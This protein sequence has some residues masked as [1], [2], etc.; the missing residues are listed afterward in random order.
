MLS[1][2]AL[3]DAGTVT[4]DNISAAFSG[5]WDARN[6]VDMAVT[7][8]SK[9][10][11]IPEAD[12]KKAAEAILPVVETKAAPSVCPECGAEMAGATMCPKCGWKYDAA[13]EAKAKEEKAAKDA[14]AELEKRSNVFPLDYGEAEVR[15]AALAKAEKD[16][17][18]GK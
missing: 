14:A 6:F 9:R 17:A 18:K 10:D 8:I 3:V 16:K 15:K 5:M 2:K 12:L 4:N 7:T 11:N 13:A 1:I